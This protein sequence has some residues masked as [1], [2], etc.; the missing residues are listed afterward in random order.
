MSLTPQKIR[1]IENRAR[2]RLAPRQKQ[3]QAAAVPECWEDFVSLCT[4]RSGG[5]IRTYAG[6][7]YVAV[8]GLTYRIS[9]KTN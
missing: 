3:Q 6:T 5:Q 4:I 9:K 7:L 1:Q 8:L 2:E